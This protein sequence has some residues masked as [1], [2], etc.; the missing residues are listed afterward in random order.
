MT[1]H[2]R[3][4]EIETQHLYTLSASESMR[5]D[6]SADTKQLPSPSSNSAASSSARSSHT[7]ENINTM[8]EE[9]DF[10]PWRN[11]DPF[12]YPIPKDGDPWETCH[13]AVKKYDDAMCTAWKDEVQN[14][15]I[16]AGLFSAVVT[17]F[18]VESYKV[19][20]DPIDDST[21]LLAQIAVELASINGRN[22]TTTTPINT[23]QENFSPSAF[24]VRLNTFWFLSLTLSL[25][26][27]MLGILALQWI[28]EYER[29]EAIS[30]RERL[31]IRQMRYESIVK[32]QIPNILRGLPVLLQLALML[33]FLG[34]LDLLRSLDAI[35]T[36]ILS[37]VVGLVFL[38]MLAT[39][40]IPGLQ[41]LF[42]RLFS[43]DLTP[44]LEQSW[45][46][47]PY[48]SP[49]S[50]AFLQLVFSLYYYP[51]VLFSY[52]LEMRSVLALERFNIFAKGSSSGDWSVFDN[53]WKNLRRPY[54]YLPSAIAWA[55]R[56]FGQGNDSLTLAIYHCI[57]DMPPY[58]A[59]RTITLLDGSGVE[60]EN[61]IGDMALYKDITSARCLTLLKNFSF[62]FRQ[63]SSIHEIELFIRICNRETR[64]EDDQFSCPYISCRKLAES[65][66][67][68]T[69]YPSELM[70]QVIH[71]LATI[72][73]SRGEYSSTNL[74][75]TGALVWHGIT[76][77]DKMKSAL[78]KPL[79]KL[80][81]VLHQWICRLHLEP[82][83]CNTSPYYIPSDPRYTFF[84]D[85]M[86]CIGAVSPSVAHSPEGYFRSQQHCEMLRALEVLFQAVFFKYSEKYFAEHP[87]KDNNWLEFCEKALLVTLP[88]VLDN[89]EDVFVDK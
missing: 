67:D 78:H 60:M 27:V 8:N 61:P 76:A 4:P 58:T 86:D 6:A 80:Y 81:A 68:S 36:I 21:R 32:W 35:I 55:A 13:K 88:G 3:T 25:A 50:W 46:S 66:T 47:C 39:T 82:A 87:W 51:L 64:N 59:R 29:Y 65:A 45:T 72:F 56:S 42:V 53:F 34:M 26:T 77:S 40:V 73:E 62:I 84:C 5:S 11:G 63:Q 10:V 17:A 57:N 12:Q 1:Q 44:D 31:E 2:G 33:F 7:A 69:K 24:A 75:T 49:Q 85:I 19:L 9:P 16:F 83:D 28:R 79:A 23:P 18:V 38:V 30:Y 89:L 22:T 14:L 48:K 43:L 70:V 41:L 74:M 54:G 20:A 15:L 37:I 71:S 52:K